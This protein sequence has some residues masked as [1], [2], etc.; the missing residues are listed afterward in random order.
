MSR[1]KLIV[2][3]VVVLG[4]LGILVYKQAKRD[5][6]L[7]QPLASAKD[8]PA[9][10]APDEIDRI[11]ITNGDKGEVV[12]EK[13]PDPKAP[14]GDAGAAMKWVLSKPIKADANQQGVK[15]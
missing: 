2:F 14:T 12:L 7:G 5:E 13:A 3:G 11:S 6:A 15:D 4:L 10:N 8:F 9:I 1:D